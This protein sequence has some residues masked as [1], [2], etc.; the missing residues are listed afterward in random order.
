MK[1]FG[2]FNIGIAYLCIISWL[3]GA[4]FGS[5]VFNQGFALVFGCIIFGVLGMACLAGDDILG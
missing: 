2:Y 1:Y 4:V 3:I 5:I